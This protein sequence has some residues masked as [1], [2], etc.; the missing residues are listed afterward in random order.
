MKKDNK[1]HEQIRM[2]GRRA[3]RILNQLKVHTVPV[4]FLPPKT[5]SE[6]AAQLYPDAQLA[7]V[8]EPNTK[9]CLRIM[10]TEKF[11]T[12]QRVKKSMR[13]KQTR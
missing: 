7:H 12:R 13:E 10:S 4:M 1:M 8:V 9:P 11:D 5:F 6:P 3:Q 2:Q